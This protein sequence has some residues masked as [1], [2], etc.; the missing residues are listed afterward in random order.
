MTKYFTQS[1]PIHV[2]ADIRCGK[3]HYSICGIDKTTPLLVMVT[4]SKIVSA[5]QD[6]ANTRKCEHYL[7]REKCSECLSSPFT[8]CVKQFLKLWSALFYRCIVKNVWQYV[9][10]FRHKTTMK[11]ALRETQTL[12]AGCSKA[13]PKIFAP[14]QT[15]FPGAQDGQNL[16]S[17]RWSIP[18]PTSPVWWG[19]M[20]VISS[21]RRNRPTNTQTTPQT[22]P[23][24]INCTAKLS[25]Q[26]NVIRQIERWTGGQTHR[27]P[28]PV[29]MSRISLL[30]RDKNSFSFAFCSG[31]A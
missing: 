29:L 19:S 1:L 31:T 15:P 26:C 20:H 12:R 25:A 10:P 18:L 17:W 30:T 28:I 23:I 21:Y 3:F 27:N 11:K 22:G 13:E 24:T 8:Y 16:I 6:S 9:Q 14:S 5:I 4:L 7:S 2:V